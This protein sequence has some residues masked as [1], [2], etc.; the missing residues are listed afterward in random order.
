MSTIIADIHC[1]PTLKPYGLSFPNKEHSPY[2][3][4][5]NSIFHY[6]PQT[7][8]DKVKNKF[9]GVTN[10]SQSN[11]TALKYGGVN[12][13]VASL[14]PIEKG[15]FRTKFGSGDIIDGLLNLVT[16]VGKNRINF[17]QDLNTGYY[18]DLIDELNFLTEHADKIFNIDGAK[19][20][21]KI[22]SSREEIELYDNEN[23][24]FVI[25]VLVSLEGAHAFFNSIGEINFQDVNFD[26]IKNELFNNI[27]DFKSKCVPLY[28]SFAHHFYNGLGGHAPSLTDFTTKIFNNQSEHLNEE[29]HQLGI[30]VIR[31][32]LDK[33][34]GKRILI[35][36]KHMSIASRKSY[37]QLLDNEYSTENIPII[38][39]HGGVRGNKLNSDLFLDE[40]INFSDEDIIRVGKS[41]GLFGIQL[42]ERRI[43][44][45]KEIT[46]FKR[47]TSRSK[48]LYHASE[49]VWRQIQH[50]AETLDHADCNAW[51]IQ[52]IGSDY[53]G[54]INPID[55]L[56]TAEDMKTLYDYLLMHAFAYTKSDNYK[57]MKNSYNKILD[58]EEIVARV[59]G[60]NAYDFILRNL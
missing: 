43:A 54:I 57:N 11:F 18:S 46:N 8:W 19:V 55:G 32:L 53:D 10:F 14:Y 49:L 21:Y 39:S 35:D 7:F 25:N 33:N 52:S 37:Y 4:R 24:E 6:D 26:N 9:A 44:S 2:Q 48:V 58:S 29:I 40:V 27:A 51:S 41:G 30:E 50:I 5:K 47:Y 42:D 45:K 36:I 60:T 23:D 13:I 22:I 34:N 38:I 3:N 16:N 1:H 20:R 17:I 31:K 56:W 12:L 28:V 59:M 15:F